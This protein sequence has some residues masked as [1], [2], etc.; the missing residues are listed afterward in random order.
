[1]PV[2]AAHLQS[3]SRFVMPTGIKIGNNTFVGLSVPQKKRSMRR[4]AMRGVHPIH[5]KRMEPNGGS[6]STKSKRP[7]D[8]RIPATSRLR[9][10]IRTGVENPGMRRSW[11][12]SRNPG[13]NPSGRR[14]LPW[15]QSGSLAP[16]GSD[17]FQRIRSGQ[18]FE[19]I[20]SGQSFQRI[21]SG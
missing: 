11:R 16:F 12:G 1:M 13:W 18:T 8:I 19:C 14:Y 6:L 2:E 10:R 15:D 4:L 20:R 3:M 21:R 5:I 9:V 7:G 17:R